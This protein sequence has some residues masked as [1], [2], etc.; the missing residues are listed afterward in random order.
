MHLIRRNPSLQKPRHPKL[1][2][3]GII[4]SL[5]LSRNLQLLKMKAESV[6]VDSHSGDDLG[7]CCN[8]T[9]REKN[10]FVLPPS[11]EHIEVNNVIRHSVANG[12]YLRNTTCKRL[13]KLCYKGRG[14]SGQ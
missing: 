10:K 14:L 5:F 3:K 2:L 12:K 1:I 8:C 6:N 4:Y 11:V 7:E 9:I 13:P